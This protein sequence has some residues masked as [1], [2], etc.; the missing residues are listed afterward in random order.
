MVASGDP[1]YGKHERCFEVTTNKVIFIEELFGKEH[2]VKLLVIK[3]IPSKV[4]KWA[5][6]P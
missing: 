2:V 1:T 4:L 3:L 6:Y 5:K